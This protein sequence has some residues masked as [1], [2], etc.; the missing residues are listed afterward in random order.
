MFG[1]GKSNSGNE[2]E[3]VKKEEQLEDTE[4]EKQLAELKNSED[5]ILKLEA[6]LKSKI[7]LVDAER[8][9][10]GQQA[11]TAP[12]LSTLDD[13]QI[14]RPKDVV[15]WVSNFDG[16]GNIRIFLREVED[17]LN[18]MVSWLDKKC[19]L[20][21]I[22]ANK[23]IGQ[24]KDL[25]GSQEADNWDDIKELL[26]YYYDVQDTPYTYLKE[27]RNKLLQNPGEPV[28]NY[29]RK[30]LEVHRKVIKAAGNKSDPSKAKFAQESE[31]EEGVW[32]FIVGL[33]DRVNERVE[34]K[35]PRTLKEAISVA[36]NA[37]SLMQER[38]LCRKISQQ[39]A[40]LR[41][42]R[43]SDSKHHDDFKK[44]TWHNDSF[45]A[46]ETGKVSR[47]NLF[48]KFCKK[49]GH[50]E[51]RCYVKQRDFRPRSQSDRPPP[52]R[53]VEEMESETSADKEEWDE[54]TLDPYEYE[55]QETAVS[56]SSIC[57]QEESIEPFDF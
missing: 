55:Q 53:V 35:N 37:E 5:E 54:V 13:R 2:N 46:V 40:D 27:Q 17:A 52:I 23:I 6:E 32:R 39:S 56:S 20:R 57:D 30:F 28:S 19:V 44:K 4:K 43:P 3:K 49:L 11:P 38:T 7:Q 8:K 48:C 36:L 51:D 24:A 21:M 42:R 18:Q 26:H 10:L 12:S 25:I 41:Q 47:K 14:L 9:R 16:S 45:K 1:L 33:T 22:I 34:N 29:A 31:E 15:S 50:T